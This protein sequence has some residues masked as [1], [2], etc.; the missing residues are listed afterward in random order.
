MNDALY[1]YYRKTLRRT[2]C[3]SFREIEKMLSCLT[4]CIIRKSFIN[5]GEHKKGE[6]QLNW[7]RVICN[8]GQIAL[9]I[10]CMLCHRVENFKISSRTV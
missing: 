8:T 9:I 3:K 4:V 1:G 5:A 6:S 10:S 7:L 2:I